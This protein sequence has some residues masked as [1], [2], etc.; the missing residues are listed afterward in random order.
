MELLIATIGGLVGG[1]LVL[2][3]EQLIIYF[4]DRNKEKRQKLIAF[5]NPNRIIDEAI[6]DRLAPGRSVELMKAVL[7]TPDN[8]FVDAVPIF[9][10]YR[11][12]EEG[13]MVYEFKS[14]EDKAA[15]EENR[16]RT[17]A[18]IY[19]F[20]NALVKI[21]SKDKETIN[22]LAVEVKDD[23]SLDISDLPLWFE[24]EDELPYKLG[25]AKVAKELVDTSRPAYEFSRYDSIFVL[26]IYTAGPLYTHYSYFGYPDNGLEEVSAESPET[27]IGCTI[28]GV[29]LHRDEFDCYVPRGWDYL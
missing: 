8:T 20:E 7:G 25:W 4:K 22:S 5:P 19:D 24:P 10:T 13:L 23:F 18:Y 21:T 14:E 3:I 28:R 15:F 16:L 17:T 29:C 26:S 6:F 12:E 11:E 27:F 1:G 9:E 2:G